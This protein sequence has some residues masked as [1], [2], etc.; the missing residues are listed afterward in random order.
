MLKV[1]IN[2]R[3][4]W[5]DYFNHS[6]FKQKLGKIEENYIIC[7]YDIEKEKLKSQFKF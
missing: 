6:F 7:E 1:N 4:S 3:I 5:K 2:E